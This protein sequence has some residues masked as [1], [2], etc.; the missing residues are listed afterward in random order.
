MPY[1]RFHFAADYYYAMLPSNIISLR[2]YAIISTCF[3]AYVFAMPIIFIYTMMRHFRRYAA[4][5]FL[6][7]VTPLRADAIIDAIAAYAIHFHYF[8]ALYGAD[9]IR[10]QPP[11]LFY[12]C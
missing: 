12:Y 11:A 5:Y 3:F 2:D 10:I 8:H 7:S 1:L 4:D 9:D 6:L